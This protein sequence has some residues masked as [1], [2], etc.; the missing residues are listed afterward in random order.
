[1][2]IDEWSELTEWQD[3]IARLK[4]EGKIRFFGVSINDHEPSSALAL[5]ASG[6]VDTVQV[7]Y[8]IFDQSP[9][10]AL[11]PLC[12]EKGIGVIVR[13]PLD[14]GGLTGNIKGDTL[15][16]PGDFR[17]N[18]FSGD[19]RKQVE[20]RVRKLS[21]LLGP[22]AS[23]PSELALRFTLTHE[24]VSTVIPGMRTV[25]HAESN[26]GYSDGRRLTPEM[27]RRLRDHT[28]DRNFY[29]RDPVSSQN[30]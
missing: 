14:E 15:F 9:E 21:P 16:A 18:Y 12:L 19:R 28:W 26:A 13:V 24:A 2:W 25:T 29:R 11:F 1:V 30:P 22:E 4:E 27:V 3:A 17:N 10:S 6:K 23:T 5:G 8:N 7:I 20:E